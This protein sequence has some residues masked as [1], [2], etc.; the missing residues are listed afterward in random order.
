MPNGNNGNKS[1][2][3]ANHTIT[4]GGVNLGPLREAPPPPTTITSNMGPSAPGFTVHPSHKG[5]NKSRNRKQRKQS[6]Q[7]AHRRKTVRRR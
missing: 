4:L 1:K 2:V 3:F 5:G 7:Q 6:K